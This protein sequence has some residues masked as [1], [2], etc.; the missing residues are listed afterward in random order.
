MIILLITG[1][2]LYFVP[3]IYPDDCI[4]R[5]DPTKPQDNGKLSKNLVKY[6]CPE[7]KYSPLG[8]LFFNALSTVFEMLMSS[9]VTLSVFS[10]VAYFLAWYPLTLLTYGTN[11]PAGLFVSGILIGCSYGRL[12][13]QFV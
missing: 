10:L 1:T 2:V 4:L 8:A 13:G 5:D 6:L 11:I 7:D 12:I 9:E 3:A